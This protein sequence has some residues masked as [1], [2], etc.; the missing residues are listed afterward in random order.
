MPDLK[1]PSQKRGLTVIDGAMVMVIIL[2]IIQMWL[3]TTALEAFLAGHHETAL[4]AAILS[5]LIFGAC[6]GLYLFVGKVD[7]ESRKP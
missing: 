1:L 7:F 5:G 4:P 6:L 3:L 2:L